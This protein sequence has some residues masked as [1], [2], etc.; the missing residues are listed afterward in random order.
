MFEQKGDCVKREDLE[1]FSCD[2][3]I[4]QVEDLLNIQEANEA[5][6]NPR[7]NKPQ[8]TETEAGEVSTNFAL[9][10][11]EKLF[12]QQCEICISK[13]VYIELSWAPN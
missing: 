11:V 6:E 13:A 2:D 7:K 4:K 8:G 10:R 3:S 9:S 5:I 1:R 12:K